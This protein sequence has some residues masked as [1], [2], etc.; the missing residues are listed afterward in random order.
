MKRLAALGTVALTVA[1]GAAQDRPVFRSAID[2]VTVDVSVRSGNAPVAGLKAADFV[3]H[4]NGVRQE[5]SMLDVE[6]LP[7]DLTL[8]LD[9]SGSMAGMIDALRGYVKN[10]QPLLRDDDLL[11]VLTVA[12]DVR[13]MFAFHAPGADILPGELA[14]GGSTSIYDGI[15]AALIHP[16]RGDR[17]H[18]AIAITDGIDTNSALSTAS[19]ND[20]SRH[21]DS[22]LHVVLL[23][24]P[25][26]D[27]PA[28]QFRM[29]H[30]TRRIWSVPQPGTFDYW[31]L[32]EVVANTGGQLDVTYAKAGGVPSLVKNVLDKFR[33]S[34]V[35]RYRPAGVTRDGWHTV[36]VKVPK[37]NELEIRARKGYFVA[38]R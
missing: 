35:L 13:Q 19:L 29:P 25:D 37:W 8:V 2:L 9:T 23:K 15:I 26:P 30:N 10:V 28:R 4:D 14:V 5:I 7:I 38:A 1:H 16:R 32:K 21:T 3:L 12:A 34:Y 22:V 11:R 6:A 27:N 33:T 17:R 20:L 18:L 31:P 36:E 24:D